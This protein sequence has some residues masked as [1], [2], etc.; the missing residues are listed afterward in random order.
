MI[1]INSKKILKK[2]ISNTMMFNVIEL[3]VLILLFHFQGISLIK[4][5]MAIYHV[6]SG[7]CKNHLSKSITI[8]NIF[9]ALLSQIQV[10]SGSFAIFSYSS[11]CFNM[12]A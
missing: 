12:I 10:S 3:E 1:I 8:D 9:I 2:V 6:F 11:V 5:S 7:N 4:E